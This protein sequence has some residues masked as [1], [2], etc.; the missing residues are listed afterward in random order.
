MVS[1]RKD[2]A[3]RHYQWQAEQQ[4]WNLFHQQSQRQESGQHDDS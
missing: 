3:G 2:E 4:H 1:G